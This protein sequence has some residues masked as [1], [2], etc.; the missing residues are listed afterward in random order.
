MQLIHND[1]RANNRFSLHHTDT[2]V[3]RLHKKGDYYQQMKKKIRDVT[4]KKKMREIGFEFEPHSLNR[5]YFTSFGDYKSHIAH[6]YW[7]N[8]SVS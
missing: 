5:G 1:N 6:A 3:Q 2:T 4:K 8:I 7:C